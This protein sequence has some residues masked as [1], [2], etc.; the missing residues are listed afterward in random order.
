[1]NSGSYLSPQKSLLV[2]SKE[3]LDVSQNSSKLNLGCK[4]ADC[5]TEKVQ[6]LLAPLKGA[7]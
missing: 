4:K 7:G 3:V 5:L 6:L 2:S 1:M